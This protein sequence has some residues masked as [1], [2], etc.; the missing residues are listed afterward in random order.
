[1][2]SAFF[3]EKWP[4][5]S[6]AKVH[7]SKHELL[8]LAAVWD[9]VGALQ[10]FRKDELRNVR[11]CVGLFAVPKDENYD[12]LILNPV[13]INSRMHTLNT[14]TRQLGHGSQLCLLHIPHDA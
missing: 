9:S 7:A 1:M 4:K 8:K 14:Y 3:W 6:R 12:R 13:V 2:R 11:E 10:I 5:V